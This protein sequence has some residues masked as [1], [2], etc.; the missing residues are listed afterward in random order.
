M[1][2]VAFHKRSDRLDAIHEKGFICE[3]LPLYSLGLN[4]IEKKWVHVKS[5]RKTKRCELDELFTEHL[6]Y[7][8]LY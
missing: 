8:N 5:M 4:P 7:A 2:N 3:F 1:D 6:D